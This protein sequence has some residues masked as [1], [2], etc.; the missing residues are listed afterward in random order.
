[1]MLFSFSIFKDRRSLKIENENNNTKTLSV[2]YGTKVP[3]VQVYIEIYS[4]WLELP[5]TSTNYHSPSLFE[6]LKFYSIF[7]YFAYF[8]NQQIT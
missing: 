3:R 5:L 8:L 2:I 7:F 4:G 6:P 1:M